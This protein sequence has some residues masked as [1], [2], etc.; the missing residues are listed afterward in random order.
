M[1]PRVQQEPAEGSREIIDRE[2]AR[3][4]RKNEKKNSKKPNAPEQGDR[5]PMA[6]PPGK[7]P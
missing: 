3:Q 5:K 4:S 6:P 1:N 2:L 7:K